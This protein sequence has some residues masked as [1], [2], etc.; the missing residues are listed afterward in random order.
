M[1]NE[2][3]KLSQAM[4]SWNRKGD[5]FVDKIQ[6]AQYDRKT[7]FFTMYYAYEADGAIIVLLADAM[8][9]I[10]R[11]KCDPMAVHNALMAIKE[12]ADVIPTDMEG[13]DNGK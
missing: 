4:V 7:D 11:D 12:Y 5:V 3:L 1:S 10:C 13:L 2:K 9:M 8:A 6:L